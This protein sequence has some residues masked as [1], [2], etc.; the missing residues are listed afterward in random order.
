MGAGAGAD[1]GAGA[2]AGAGL[3]SDPCCDAGGKGAQAR[4]GGTAAVL[5]RLRCCVWSSCDGGKS[6][7]CGS[8]QS[9]ARCVVALPT[10]PAPVHSYW[11]FTRLTPALA[12]PSAMLGN[13]H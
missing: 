5:R 9:C 13:C 11:V 2:G 8:S 3:L 7:G 6:A 4:G 10:S 1:A 12:T